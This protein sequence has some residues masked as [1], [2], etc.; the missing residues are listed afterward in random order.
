MISA[1]IS[2]LGEVID[3]QTRT[4]TLEVELDNP[5]EKLK[6]NMLTSVRI[7]DYEDKNALVVPSIYT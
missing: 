3:Q 2:R 4:F 1:T 5:G 6:P 7:Q